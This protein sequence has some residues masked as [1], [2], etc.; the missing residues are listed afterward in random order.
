MD[1][2]KLRFDARE[3]SY[4]QFLTKKAGLDYKRK[5]NAITPRGQPSWSTLVVGRCVSKE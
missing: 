2:R 1:L 5:S 4:G 3:I